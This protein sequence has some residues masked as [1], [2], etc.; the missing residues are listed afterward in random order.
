MLSNGKVTAL[1]ELIDAR[2][3]ASFHI[4]VI[5]LC[6]LVICLGR[7]DVSPIGV[8]TPSLVQDGHIDRH[9]LGSVV[10]AALLGI[11]RGHSVP[12]NRHGRKVVQ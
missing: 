2:P 10:S 9:T 11:T 6:F 12:G 3:F 8:I 4:K 5:T 1:P 7:F